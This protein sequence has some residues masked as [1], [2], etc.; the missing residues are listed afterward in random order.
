M[1]GTCRLSIRHKNGK[2]LNILIVAGE[3]FAQN[4]KASEVTITLPNR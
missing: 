1:P 3:D 2:M 4:E